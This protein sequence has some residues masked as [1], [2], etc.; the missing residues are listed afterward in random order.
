MKNNTGMVNFV[1]Q[2]TGLQGVQIFSSYSR[3]VYEGVSGGV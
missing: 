2:R 3:C 1:C